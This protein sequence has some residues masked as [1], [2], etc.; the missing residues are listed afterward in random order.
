[1]SSCLTP[2]T[3]TNSRWIINLSVKGKT[4]ELPYNTGEPIHDTQVS[5]D[6]LSRTEQALTLRKSADRII[7]KSITAH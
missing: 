4:T 5:K 2:P 3:K 6:F 7:L 1:M